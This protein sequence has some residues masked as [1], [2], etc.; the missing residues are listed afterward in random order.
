MYTKEQMKNVHPD[1]AANIDRWRLYADSYEGGA[2]YRHG[3]YLFKYQLETM[4]EYEQRLHETPLE[5]HCRRTV[6]SYSSF[7]YG[8]NIER[9]YGSIENNPNL[10]PFLK[11]ADLD[12]R[13]YSSFIRESGKFASIYG[14]VWIFVDKPQSNAGTRAE[15]LGQGIR[16]YVSLVSPENVLDWKYERQPNGYMQ[17]VYVKVRIDQTKDM[18]KCKLYFTVIE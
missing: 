14:A 1:Y 7:I 17:L 5:N 9:T 10:E 18:M 11:D 8:A 3:E 15:E 2:A 6:D 12:G 13:S 4:G 16:P